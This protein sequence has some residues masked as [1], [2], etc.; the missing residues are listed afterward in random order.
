MHPYK[1]ASVTSYAVCL[2]CG[3]LMILAPFT[4]SFRSASR[5]ARV[6]FWLAG[7][8][9]ILWGTIGMTIAFGHLSSSI[10]SLFRL[11]NTFLAGM[12][13][14]ILLLLLL[15]GELMRF[16]SADTKDVSKESRSA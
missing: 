13:A 10:H 4:R 1:I 11:Y 16:G 9:A 14:G 12:G 7:T 5:L 2:V 6:G 8:I 3:V 15:S